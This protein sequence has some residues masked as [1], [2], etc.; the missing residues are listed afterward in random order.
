MGPGTVVHA[1]LATRVTLLT[2]IVIDVVALVAVL[3]AVSVSVPFCAIEDTN[4]TVPSAATVMPLLLVVIGIN[5]QAPFVGANVIFNEFAVIGLVII[6][7]TVTV[8]PLNAIVTPLSTC[9]VWAANVGGVT[10]TACSACVTTTETPSV[11]VDPYAVDV[12]RIVCDV[13][14]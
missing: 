9:D 12:A 7:L 4:M 8:A 10:C 1:G 5:V 14:E 2:L 11:V 6:P 3:V 13:L